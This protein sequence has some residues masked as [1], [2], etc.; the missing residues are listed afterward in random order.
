MGMA[1]AAKPNLSF[2]TCHN[3]THTQP[4]RSHE[5]KSTA[6][7]VRDTAKDSQSPPSSGNAAAPHA[8]HCPTNV[9]KEAGEAEQGQQRTHDAGDDAQHLPA[10][11]NHRRQ[12][13]KVRLPQHRAHTFAI[14]TYYAYGC[15]ACEGRGAKTPQPMART[16][17][18][19]P[20]AGRVNALDSTDRD[21]A[22]FACVLP[23]TRQDMHYYRDHATVSH[24]RVNGKHKRHT[25]ER[26]RHNQPFRRRWW[27]TRG[28][29]RAKNQ[30]PAY[31]I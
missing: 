22:S 13:G 5:R 31:P 25:R 12:L 2:R 17:P 16:L 27:G 26:G 24:A 28:R 30:T 29:G 4:H 3:V 11:V 7:T 9:H 20:V 21:P 6:A 18:V 10:P 23:W 8:Q 15:R 19:M 14:F 1:A